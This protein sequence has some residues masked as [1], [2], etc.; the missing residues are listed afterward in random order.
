MENEEE[1]A[2]HR[3]LQIFFE[4]YDSSPITF[5]VESLSKVI[6]RICK[7]EGHRDVSK[8]TNQLQY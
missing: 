7:S 3:F 1:T 5:E 2:V 6:D 4:K 8:D